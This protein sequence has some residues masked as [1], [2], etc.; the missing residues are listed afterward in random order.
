MYVTLIMKEINLDNFL[1]SRREM[2]QRN[3]SLDIQTNVV[4]IA[5]LSI[6]LPQKH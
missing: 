4:T 2:F 3:Y 6:D 5:Y 1:F